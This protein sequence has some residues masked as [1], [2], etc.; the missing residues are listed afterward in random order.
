MYG[1]AAVQLTA[2][3]HMSRQR[4]VHLMTARM[5]RGSPSG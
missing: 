5:S 3:Q 4:W 2:V 1:A